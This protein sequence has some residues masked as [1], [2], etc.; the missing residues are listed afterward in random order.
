MSL[1]RNSILQ[2]L[3]LIVAHSFTCICQDQIITKKGQ[4]IASKIVELSTTTIKYKKYENLNGPTYNI[5]KTDVLFIKYQNGTKVVVNEFVS[6]LSSP[7]PKVKENTET[8]NLAINGNNID[9]AKSKNMVANAPLEKKSNFI[10]KRFGI[11][12]GGGYTNIFEN[13]KVDTWSKYSNFPF[14]I[15]SKPSIEFGINY[16]IPIVKNLLFLKSEIGILTGKYNQKGVIQGINITYDNRFETLNLKGIVELRVPLRN[17]S[18]TFIFGVGPGFNFSNSKSNTEQTLKDRSS[19]NNITNIEYSN[20]IR[21]GTK[22]LIG[23]EKNNS[24]IQIN[25]NWIKFSSSYP[26]IPFAPFYTLGITYEH[27]IF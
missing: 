6:D 12:A 11:F 9:V 15:E 23:F 8:S 26:E 1:L 4:E 5:N 19:I 17:D 18:E 13:H 25:Y 24:T 10:K 22:A 27:K 2:S 16:T 7:K 14:T 3:F 20:K 21:L